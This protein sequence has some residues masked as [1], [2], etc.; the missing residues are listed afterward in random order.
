MCRDRCGI[1]AEARDSTNDLHELILIDFKGRYSSKVGNGNKV[2]T[3]LCQHC[4]FELL[5]VWI[6]I[7]DPFVDLD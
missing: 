6:G 7:T 3:D 2:A 4:A 1:T 5:G